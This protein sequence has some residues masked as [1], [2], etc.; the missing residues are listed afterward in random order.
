MAESIRRILVVDDEAII[1]EFLRRLL[2]AGAPR[3]QVET[4]RSGAEAVEKAASLRPHLVI[5][6]IRMPDGDG[7]LVCEAIHAD[8]NCRHTVVLAMTAASEPAVAERVLSAGAVE[9][10]RKPF[11]FNR[12]V[13]RHIERVGTKPGRTL[14]R[15]RRIEDVGRNSHALHFVRDF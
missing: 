5:L 8:P 3:F 9:C 7:T 4:A 14:G 10:L 1:I 13:E 15:A 6:D 2:S 11:A 12:R